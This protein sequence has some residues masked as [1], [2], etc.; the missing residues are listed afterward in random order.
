ME[1]KHFSL[2]FGKFLKRVRELRPEHRA[3]IDLVRIL[4]GI[5]E[6]FF[7][8]QWTVAFIMDRDCLRTPFPVPVDD[9]VPRDR[10]QPRR[11]PLDGLSDT[12]AGNQLIEDVLQNILGI[13]ISADPAANERKEPISLLPDCLR[14]L[15]IGFMMLVT[16]FQSGALYSLRRMNG[17]NIVCKIGK[18]GQIG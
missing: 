6:D 1:D 4:P 10:E 3:R 8:I 7:E 11:Q 12:E 17:Q 13:S 2:G 5:E 14:D 16:L 9:F 18:T 15:M